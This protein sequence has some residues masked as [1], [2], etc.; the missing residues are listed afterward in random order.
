MKIVF[1]MGSEAILNEVFKLETK[2]DKIR[3]TARKN[4]VLDLVL[5]GCSF[6]VHL[7]SGWCIRY[8][9]D[10]S[11]IAILNNLRLIELKKASYISEVKSFSVEWECYKGYDAL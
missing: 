3:L 8:L 1:E 5:N 7:K 6:N 4:I 11:H 10:F 9:K 2:Y